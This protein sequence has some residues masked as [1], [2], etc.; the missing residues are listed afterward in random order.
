MPFAKTWTEEIVAEWLLLKGYLVEIGLPVA[1]PN[2]GGRFET[3]V[4]GA[5]VEANTLKIVHVEVGTLAEGQRSV[6]SLQKKFSNNI[7]NTVEEKENTIGRAL[8]GV[9]QTYREPGR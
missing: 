9:L 8:Q 7:Y 1:A 5:K 4:V 2:V 3:D 6:I